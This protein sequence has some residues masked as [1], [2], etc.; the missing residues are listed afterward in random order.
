MLTTHLPMDIQSDADFRRMK[1]PPR[2]S[3]RRTNDQRAPPRATAGA[4]ARKAWSTP[5][6]TNYAG[7]VHFIGPG[8]ATL[9]GGSTLGA[10][11]QHRDP[12]GRPLQ[13]RG[14]RRR[15]FDEATASR[16]RVALYG[17]ILQEK[18]LKGRLP[19]Q[20]FVIDW[21][22]TE[23]AKDGIE[24]GDIVILKRIVRP[25]YRKLKSQENST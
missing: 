19:Y 18:V 14:G 6:I 22:H 9:S 21:V 12:H 25:T 13:E 8:E 23:L 4:S 7:V 16:L 10:K 24:A 1:I 5:A 2:P 17:W 20:T 3:N 15:A 11:T